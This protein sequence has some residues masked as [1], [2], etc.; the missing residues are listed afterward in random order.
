MTNLEAFADCI[1]NGDRIP[2]TDAQ[3]IG[4]IAVLEAICKSAVTNMP[5]Q[6]DDM[7]EILARPV[8]AF[9]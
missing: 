4:N 2:F 3:K 7:A 5:V 9:R 8:S 6:I 1:L